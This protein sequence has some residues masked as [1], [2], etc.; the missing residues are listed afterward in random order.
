MLDLVNI[1]Q[2]YNLDI[3]PEWKETIAR[4]Q[5]WFRAMCHP[6]GDI[7]FF[8]DSAIGVA[9]PLEAIEDYSFRLDLPVVRNPG[10]MPVVNLTESG[11]V[12]TG[13]G[14]A[15]IFMDIGSAGPG[16]LPAHAHAGTFS[17]EVSIGK[18]RVFVNSGIS[19]Y[20]SGAV[21]LR[22]R[23][24]ASHNTLEVD[25]RDSSEVWGGFRMGRRAK[26]EKS[27]VQ[28]KYGGN[29]CVSGTHNGYRYLNGAVKHH[30]SW[31]VSSKKI[32]I[33]DKITGKGIHKIKIIYHVH[34]ACN[35][36]SDG[37]NGITITCID[38]LR[39]CSLMFEG[40]GKSVIYPSTYQPEFGLSLDNQCI[41]YFWYG[42]V[43]TQCITTI[44]F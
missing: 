22:Q 28:T 32:L 38:G 37:Q 21:R 25:E 27:S 14:N 35:A 20:G 13:I 43:P 41:I 34:P 11:Y 23:G 42:P 9:A 3:E 16:Y 6:D 4:M 26:V 15:V 1:Y 18:Q 7:A 19:E 40:P 17:F 24:T 12:R 5:Y 10:I 8:N 36:V 2:A 31:D 33:T 44:Y 39:L 29:I 30:R